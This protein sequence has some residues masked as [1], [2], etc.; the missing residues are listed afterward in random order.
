MACQPSNVSMDEG[1]EKF[2]LALT[3]ATGGWWSTGAG[4]GTIRNEELRL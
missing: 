1:D 3:S 2:L 4:T